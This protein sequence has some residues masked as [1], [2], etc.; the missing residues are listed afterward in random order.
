[1]PRRRH[2]QAVA[3]EPSR[4]A[5]L[6]EARGSWL[7][8]LGGVALGLAIYYTFASI[9]S[10]NHALRE[11]TSNSAVFVLRWMGWPAAREGLQVVSGGFRLLVVTEHTPLAS[12]ALVTGAAMAYPAALRSKLLCVLIAGL[13]LYAINAVR[14]ASL[15]YLGGKAPAPLVDVYGLVWQSL[16]ILVPLLIW[17]LWAGRDVLKQRR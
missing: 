3:V 4:R 14:V 17:L 16:M 5:A 13:A 12:I 1:M 9:D 8:A 6:P 10:V 11:A 7:V 15:V 2:S